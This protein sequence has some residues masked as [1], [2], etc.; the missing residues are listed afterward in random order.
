[1]HRNLL[2]NVDILKTDSKAALIRNLRLS[3]TPRKGNMQIGW[4][5]ISEKDFSQMPL[6]IPS[7]FDNEIHTIYGVVKVLFF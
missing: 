3:I 4:D 2:V 6:D 1:M 5:E 7:I